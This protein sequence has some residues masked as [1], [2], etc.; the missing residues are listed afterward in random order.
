MSNIQNILTEEQKHK[1]VGYVKENFY[2]MLAVMADQAANEIGINMGSEHTED[3][4][5]EC[6][7][8][9][10]RG[11]LND[12]MGEIIQDGYDKLI[13]MYGSDYIE[14]VE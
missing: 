13:K 6:I 5:D 10:V 8:M 9:I 1:L 3:C 4:D 7:H 2:Y 14:I 11:F 12:V